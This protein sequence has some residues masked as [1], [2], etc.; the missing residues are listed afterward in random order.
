MAELLNNPAIQS[1][2]LPFLIAISSAWLLRHL[3]WLWAG[4]GFTIAYYCSVYLVI[5]AQLTPITSTKKIVLLGLAA[6]MV[7]LILDYLKPQ[8]LIKLFIMALSAIAASTWL[9]WPVAMRQSGLELYQLIAFPALYMIWLSSFLTS[10]KDT[11]SEEDATVSC[12]LGFTTGIIA[13]LAASVL[14]GQLGIAIGAAASAYILLSFSRKPLQLGLNF[15]YPVAIL[16][17]LIGIAA[18]VYAK[19]PW[20]SLIPI[21]LMPLVSYIPAG[22]DAHPFKRSLILVAIS[23]PLIASAIFLTWRTTGSPSF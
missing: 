6:V 5:G 22:M 21:A 1:G 13:I 14:L 2:F 18:V 23:T 19:L 7:G 11:S 17:G 20:Y 12:L 15:T 8:P 10:I 16:G 3:G 9:V 4:L